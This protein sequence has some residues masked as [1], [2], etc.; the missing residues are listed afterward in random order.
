MP[1]MPFIP[2][3]LLLAFH[4]L[5]AGACL[6]QSTRTDNTLALDNPSNM[7]LAV[8]EDVGWLAGHWRTAAFGGHA[9]EI[10]SP[11][12]G[13][14]MMGMFKIVR[15]GS[16]T[17]YELF[18]LVEENGS[19]VIK[20]KHFNADLTG[21]E[22]ADEF[23]AFP[24]V[25]LEPDAVYFAGLTYR[26]VDESTLRAYLALSQEGELSETVFHYDRVQL[27]ADER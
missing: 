6:G 8:I 5:H 13:D 22:Q 9:E 19:L 21:W 18:T 26:R 4:L 7:P 24:L 23:V 2:I 14:S 1:R 27:P 20:L 10:W 16:S 17:L 15:D 11:P 12:F 25:R 3:A